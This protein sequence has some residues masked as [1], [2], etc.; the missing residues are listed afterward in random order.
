MLADVKNLITK[1][2][3]LGSE[4]NI[5]VINCFYVMLAWLSIGVVH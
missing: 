4:D 1:E 3:G 2:G 5:F